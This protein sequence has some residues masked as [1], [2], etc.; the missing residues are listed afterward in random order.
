[1]KLPYCCKSQRRP[2]AHTLKEKTELLGCGDPHGGG[3]RQKDCCEFENSLDC[4][5]QSKISSGGWGGRRQNFTRQR[6]PLTSG[7]YL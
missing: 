7:A 5:V 4:S 3:V 1:M 6:C 2:T